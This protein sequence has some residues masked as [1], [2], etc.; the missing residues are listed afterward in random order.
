MSYAPNLNVG[1]EACI[2]V[3]AATGANA[4]SSMLVVGRP[5]SEKCLIIIAARTSYR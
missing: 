2:A 5:V 4:T 3:D 1:A